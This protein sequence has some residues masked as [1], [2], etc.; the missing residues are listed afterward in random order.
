VTGPD[1][2]GGDV[3]AA[4]RA[5]RRPV[6]RLLDFSASI[7]PLGPSKRVLR[8]AAEAWP[9]TCHY[10]DPTC[11]DLVTAL[12]SRWKL[13]PAH[14][15]I[16]NGSSELL[17][18]LPRALAIRR[19]LILGPTFSEYA[20][21]VTNARGR[22]TYLHATR[23]DCYQIPVMQ[24]LTAL[25]TNRS[26][27]DAFFL[28]NP[29]SPTGQVALS[30][31]VLDLVDVAARRK[32]WIVVDETFVDYCEAHSVVGSIARAPR[33]VVVRSFTKFYA[34]PG[35]R[36]GYLVAAEEPAARLRRLQPP[37]AVN[38]LAQAAAQAALEDQR[39]AQRS[40]AFMHRERTRLAKA[41]G[42]TPGLTVFPSAANFLLV[43]LP[44]SMPAAH[45]TQTLRQQGLLIR[46][47][48]AIPGLN[49]RTVRIAVRTAAENRRLVTALSQVLKA[50]C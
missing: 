37:W 26:R 42:A 7:N 3:H 21:A 17:H 33:L 39:H 27:F 4:A 9:L 14:F 24:A 28:C 45:V 40:L 48:S 20:R 46:D 44:P 22:V 25:R 16:G 49:G 5:L 34:L 11:H 31:D 1:R 13:A 36:I 29:N 8:A 47:C 43:E 19:V 23:K 2:H 12:A 35:L 6:S 41:L 18:L 30:Q 15:L 38:V 50:E 32:V 10:P